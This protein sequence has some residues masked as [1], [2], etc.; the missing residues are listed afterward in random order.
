MTPDLL[1]RNPRA[2]DPHSPGQPPAPWTEPERIR[3]S[4]LRL[5]AAFSYL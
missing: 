2:P 4:P 1:H 5:P 3:L